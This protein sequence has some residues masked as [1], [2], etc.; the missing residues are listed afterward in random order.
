MKAVLEAAETLR[1][2]QQR[3]DNASREFAQ[4]QAKLS[5]AVRNNVEAKA[6]L[7]AA[8]DQLRSAVT[9]ETDKA[10]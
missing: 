3:A 7:A 6:L 10:K 4:A 2:A 9:T 1:V 5:E 8:F